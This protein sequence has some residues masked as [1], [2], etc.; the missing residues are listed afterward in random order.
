[1]YVR[2][3]AGR[4]EMVPG[5]LPAGRIDAFKIIVSIGSLGEKN[6]PIA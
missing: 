2:L 3:A 5:S 4:K 6:A 1:M